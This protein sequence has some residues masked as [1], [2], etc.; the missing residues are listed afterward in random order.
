MK[1]HLR[2]LTV[3]ILSFEFVLC[4]GFSYTIKKMIIQKILLSMMVC[5]VVS[6][7]FLGWMIMGCDLKLPS[8]LLQFLISSAIIKLCMIIL[9][10]N[11]W[12]N[13]KYGQELGFMYKCG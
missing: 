3:Y 10:Q 2:S 5:K 1:R 11:I 9:S 6:D 13:F 8:L 12:T 4:M 7:D